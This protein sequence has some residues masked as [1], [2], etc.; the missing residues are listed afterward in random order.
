MIEG[1]IQ[2]LPLSDLLLWIALTHRTGKLTVTQGT[3][4]SL[5]LYFNKGELAAASISA[6][7]LLDS[8]DKIRSVLSLVL[9]WRS[10]AFNFAEGPAHLREVPINLHLSVEA[11]LNEINKTAE[12]GTLPGGTL[13][14]HS[15]TF[16]LADTLRLQV[17]EHLLKEDFTVP[18][19]P[20]IAMRVLELTRD[21]NFSLRE[22]SNLVL[23]DQAVTAR[24]LRYANS[25]F[26]GAGREV[27]SLPLAVQRLGANEVFNI[28]L[29]TSLQA[30]RVGRDHFAAEK[31]RLWL[32]S[33]TAAFIARKLT[34]KAQLNGHTG[35]LCG[36]LMDFGINV[37]YSLLQTLFAQRPDFQT[38]PSYVIEE[39]VLDCHARLGRTVGER[40]RLPQQVVEAMAYHHC[41]GVLGSDTP[42]VAVAALADHL[43]TLALNAP[44]ATL[45]ELLT[46]GAAEQLA[47]QPAAQM[48]KLNADAAAA[49]LQG[50][51][52][53]LQQAREFVQD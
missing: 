37:L 27:D 11:M 22:L 33:T 23:T 12:P 9:T 34:V 45:P 31:R 14:E 41:F 3:T 1:E 19:M 24:V 50:L 44:S 40:W 25:I 47:S 17:V 38:V 51:P 7:T 42:Y 16:T 32:Y 26:Y 39:I 30:R 4:H 35:F 48:L 8:S 28:V 20:Q 46:S 10:G 2:T 43:A 18:S 15:E 52:E 29:A 49:V 6:L 5:E 53:V 13:R 21:D 36:L